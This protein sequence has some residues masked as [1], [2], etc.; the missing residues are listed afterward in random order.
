MNRLAIAG[1]IA[2]IAILGVLML[3]GVTA[4]PT[5]KASAILGRPSTISLPPIVNGAQEIALKATRYGTYQPNYLFVKKGIPVRIRYS[6]DAEAGCGREV[7]FPEFRVR[8]Y[9]PTNGDAL[10]EFTPTRA[11]RFPFHCSMQMFRGTIEVVE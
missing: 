3:M 2:I 11:G 7:I 6:A 9:A 4:T 1:I 8:K 5:G 10:I